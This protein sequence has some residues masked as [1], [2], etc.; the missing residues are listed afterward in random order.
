MKQVTPYLKDKV[1]G[2]LDYADGDT[3]KERYI[4]VSKIIF[5]DEDGRP[6]QFTW[7]TIQTWWYYYRQHGSTAPKKRIDCNRPRK[8]TPEELLAA[9]EHALPHFNNKRYNTTA[10]YR[11]C[12]EIGVLSKEQIAE[13]TFRRHVKRFDLLTPESKTN[14]KRRQAFAKAHANDMWQCDTLIGPYI[15]EG[16][17]P[18][19]T[20]LIALIDDASRVIT[21]GQFYHSDNTPNLIDCFQHAIFKRGVPR[22]IYVDN[23]SNYVLNTAPPS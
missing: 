21:H 8:V 15:R 1:L 20:Y 9:I 22:A 23:G 14:N 4:S 6:R 16:G 17:K 5:K 19:R 13:T 12:I 2:A 10:I 11:K 18:I 3:M 7:R